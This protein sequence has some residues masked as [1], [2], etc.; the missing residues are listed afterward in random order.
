MQKRRKISILIQLSR[1]VVED[2]Y[3][4]KY[5]H[6]KR[7]AYRRLNNKEKA[8]DVVQDTMEA[9]CKNIYKEIEIYNIDA[10]VYTI[11]KYKCLNQFKRSSRIQYF[12]NDIIEE[13]LIKEELSTIENINLNNAINELEKM[14]RKIIIY[15]FIYGF[16]NTEIS[17][18]CGCCYRTVKRRIDNSLKILK[19]KLILE[20]AKNINQLPV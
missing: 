17:K 18:I 5:R 14:D 16:N 12:Q 6:L 7:I 2:I 20:E 3:L 11:L 15:K 13:S 8:E 4:D 19:S 10:W 1:K 9:I